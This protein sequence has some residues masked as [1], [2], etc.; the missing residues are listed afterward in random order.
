MHRHGKKKKFVELVERI[1]VRWGYTST[2]GR[3]YALLLISENP[4]TINDLL[5]LTDL[6]RT[7]ISTSLKRLVGDDLV[8]V[9]REKKVKYFSPNPSFTEKFMEQPR[10]LLNKEVVPLVKIVEELSE[11]ASSEAQKRKLSEMEEDLKNLKTLLEMFIKI[12]EEKLKD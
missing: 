2:E 6:S 9:R 12:E 3:I 11:K 4:L 8:N 1:M 5:N 10:E 7:S